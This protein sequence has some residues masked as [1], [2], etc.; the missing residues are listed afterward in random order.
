[1]T[2]TR[3]TIYREVAMEAD[4]AFGL[5]NGKRA[6]IRIVTPPGMDGHELDVDIE[7]DIQFRVSIP[8]RRLVQAAPG[9]DGAMYLA[10]DA[11]VDALAG[12]EYAPGVRHQIDLAPHDPEHD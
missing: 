9:P 4:H 2:D 10:R 8:G 7:G 12:S 3:R 1:M 6:E 11:V 5:P